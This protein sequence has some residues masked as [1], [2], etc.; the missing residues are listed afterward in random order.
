[1]RPAAYAAL[2]ASLD[3]GRDGI[4]G[5]VFFAVMQSRI[6]GGA[7]LA[8]AI[9]H[10]MTYLPAES[11]CARAMECVRQGHRERLPE[12]EC[13]ETLVA[14]HGNENFTH[15]PLNVALTL[16]A[17]LY[18]GGDFVKSI[19]LAVNGG[20]DTDCTAATAGATLGL[21]H[22]A[23]KIPR[24]WAAPLGE[25]VFIGPG[26]QG[27]NA[28][29]TLGELAKRTIRLIGKLPPVKWDSGIWDRLPPEVDL[30]TL[31]GTIRLAPLDGGPPVP[32][33]NGELPGEVKRAGG[34]TWQWD[35]AAD[36]PREI[37]C[38]ARRGARLFIDG[39]PVHET[40]VGLPYVPAP[41]RVPPE[42]RLAICPSAGTHAVR[43]ELNRREPEQEASVILVYP[44]FHLCPWTAVELPHHAFLPPLDSHAEQKPLSPAAP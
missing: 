16:W 2:D 31:P 32:W 38:L 6:A 43:L 35:V 1:M 20:Y 8:E 30:A 4:A 33:A 40:P 14:R 9:R 18:G 44:N 7:P 26:I 25:G 37:V 21:V 19:L 28:P 12:W 22:G 23:E 11:E 3:H 13:W 5:E 36:E 29:K 17:L 41:H 34:A 24:E 39:K 42:T 10:A 15:A 27:I